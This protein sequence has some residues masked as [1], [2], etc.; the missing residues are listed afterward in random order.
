MRACGASSLV[1]V[2]ATISIDDVLRLL[3]VYCVDVTCCACCSHWL[4]C[5][6]A[7]SFCSSILLILTHLKQSIMLICSYCMH[8]LAAAEAGVLIPQQT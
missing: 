8:R 2:R 3:L 5:A 1:A 6:A 7:A 4:R